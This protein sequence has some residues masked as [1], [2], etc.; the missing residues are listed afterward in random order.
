MFEVRS[1]F[2][3]PHVLVMA[4]V[5][6]GAS[7][8]GMPVS[9]QGGDSCMTRREAIAVVGSGKAVPLREVRGAAEQAARGEMI[10]AELCVRNG[11]TVYV[12][13]VLSES[14]KVVYVSLNA[15]SGQLINMR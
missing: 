5:L 1:L 4:A 12:I 8:S 11:Q 7:L 3:L 13:T 2:R 15:A 10:N 9:A 6:A 14:G